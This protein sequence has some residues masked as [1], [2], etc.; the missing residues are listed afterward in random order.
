MSTIHTILR[1]RLY[2]GRFMWKGKL[3]EGKHE[4]LVTVE[5]W[6]RAQSVLDARSGRK[7]KRG[8]HAFAFFR[9]DCLHTM[10]LR[11]GRRDQMAAVRLLSLHW[12]RR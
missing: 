2:S 4:P 12:L 3:I 10:R 6:E 9:V 11:G 8:R 1:N 5:L 7:A